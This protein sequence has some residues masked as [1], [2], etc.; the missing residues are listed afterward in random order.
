MKPLQFPWTLKP[1]DMAP[2][3]ALLLDTEPTGERR[4]GRKAVTRFFEFPKEED[5]E[6]NLPV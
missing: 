2:S 3:V 1:P 4:L 6:G 5:M